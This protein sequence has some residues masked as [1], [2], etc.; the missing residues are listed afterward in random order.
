MEKPYFDTLNMPAKLMKN[1]THS[2]LFWTL[3]LLENIEGENGK[4]IKL[5]GK[6]CVIFT[7]TFF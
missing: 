7:M 1:S 5:Q 4:N 3:C 6:I 2:P